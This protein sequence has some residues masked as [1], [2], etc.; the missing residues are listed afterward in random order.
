M[1]EGDTMLK[2]EHT[3]EMILAGIA[4][5]KT[6]IEAARRRLAKLPEGQVPYPEHK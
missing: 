5:Y 1:S 6:R 3:L 2:L 4:G